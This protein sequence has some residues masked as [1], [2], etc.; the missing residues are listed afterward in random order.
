MFST[1]SVIECSILTSWI[2]GVLDWSCLFPKFF[3]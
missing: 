1:N 2:Y 3:V